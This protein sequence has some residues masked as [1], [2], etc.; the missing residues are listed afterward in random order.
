VLDNPAAG[1]I[2]KHAARRGQTP[3]HRRTRNYVDKL[4]L[5]ESQRCKDKLGLKGY[6]VEQVSFTHDKMKYQ[7]RL[8]TLFEQGKVWIPEEYMDLTNELKGYKWDTKIN[9]DMV[10]ALMLSVID[11]EVDDSQ[12]IYFKA[13]RVRR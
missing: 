8:R 2:P 3:K 1:T 6:Y 7:T 5:G 13:G 4:P 9:D 10:V 11:P 12:G